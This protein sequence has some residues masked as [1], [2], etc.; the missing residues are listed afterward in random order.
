MLSNIPVK[1]FCAIYGYKATIRKQLNFQ[2]Y[3]VIDQ[4]L[5]DSHKLILALFMSCFQ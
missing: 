4:V 3:Y 2:N 5:S 1:D